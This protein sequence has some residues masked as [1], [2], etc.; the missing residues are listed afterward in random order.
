MREGSLGVVV[1]ERDA[2]EG[3][4]VEIS[5]TLP[6]GVASPPAVFTGLRPGVVPQLLPDPERP[7]TGLI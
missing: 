4:L 7:E 3:P 5:L 6:G 1:Q 2:V